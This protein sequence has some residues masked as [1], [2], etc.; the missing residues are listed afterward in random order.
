MELQVFMLNLLPTYLLSYFFMALRFEKY[1]EI[2]S[3]YKS[4]LG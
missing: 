1:Y 3:E 2:A 4:I